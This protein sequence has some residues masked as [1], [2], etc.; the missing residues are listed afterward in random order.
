MKSKLPTKY[1][2]LGSL[3]TGP[4]HGYEIRRFLRNEMDSTWQ[5]STSQLYALLKKMEK[6]RLLN[7][8]VELQNALPSKRIFNITDSGRELF[9]EW[10]CNPTE[11]VR[12]LRVEFMAKIFFYY[13]YSLN[14]ATE[15][16]DKQIIY[17]ND[18]RYKITQKRLNE[19]NFYNRLVYSYREQT[20]ELWLQWIKKEAVPFIKIVY[21]KNGLSNDRAIEKKSDEIQT[22][23]ISSIYI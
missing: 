12:D 21:Q 7:S 11:H 3:Y 19:S 1:I 23:P 10:M 22:Q 16:I 17:L 20:I 15:L 2:L 14:G 9:M 6:D 8:E 4:K 18:T 5:V 13:R